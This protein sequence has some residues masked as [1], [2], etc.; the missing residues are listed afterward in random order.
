MVV[1]LAGRESTV[2]DIV[3]GIVGASNTVEDMLAV[4]GSVG[5]IGVAGLKAE[6]V[7]AHEVVP[8]DDLLVVAGAI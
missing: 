7:A 3:R 8:L 4:V 1:T 2:L 5:A 6:S